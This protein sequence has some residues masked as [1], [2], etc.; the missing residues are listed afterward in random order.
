MSPLNEAIEDKELSK[1]E[2]IKFLDDEGS[3]EKLDLE[4]EKPKEKKE[5]EEEEKEKPLEEELEEELEEPGEEE[6]ELVTPVRR[7]EIL[8]KYPTLFKDFPYLER[9][10]YREQKFTELLP[11]I[12]DARNAVE[13]S[14]TLDNFEKDLL[15]GNTENIL[16]AVKTH[17]EKVFSRIVDNYIDTLGK[18]DKDAYYHVLGNTV[19]NTISAM[20]S[21]SKR[22]NNETLLA[23]AQVLNQFVFGSSEFSAP[24]K[25]SI[26]EKKEGGEEDKIKQREQAFTQ[27]QYESAR[28]D[29]TTRTDNVL[30]ATIE[31]NIDPRNS[32][33]DYV[34]KSASREA[35]ESLSSTN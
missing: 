31:G 11:T 23:A 18:V 34:K 24:T 27:K 10:Y 33:T 15:S 3:E 13:K 16:K 14:K 1:E 12:D 4:E 25:L 26:E 7:R 21:E 35:M 9:A 19:K 32:M 5:G 6:L 20:V 22:S 28:D 2:V 8:A 30:K 29:L 17:D